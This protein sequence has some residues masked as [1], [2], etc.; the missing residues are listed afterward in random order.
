LKP[1]QPIPKEKRTVFGSGGRSDLG[2]VTIEIAAA[3]KVQTGPIRLLQ[4]LEGRNSGFGLEHILAKPG[5]L[6]Q[7][8]SFGFRDV[9]SYVQYIATN[10]SAVAT[11]DS[12]RLIFQ[13]DYA[14]CSHELICQWDTALRAWSVT[15]IIPKRASRNLNIIWR[16]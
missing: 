4:G 12:G 14:G 9:V 2:F 1:I 8:E 16:R 5:R 13:Q 11:E 15:T 7:I 3:C 10:F 6:R